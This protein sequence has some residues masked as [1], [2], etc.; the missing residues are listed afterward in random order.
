[1][2]TEDHEEGLGIKDLH[3]ERPNLLEKIDGMES[4]TY[5]SFL[6]LFFI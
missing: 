2:E 5:E 4:F 3:V 6:V 1:M